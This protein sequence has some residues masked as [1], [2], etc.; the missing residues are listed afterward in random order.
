[1]VEDKMTGSKDPKS[2]KLPLLKPIKRDIANGSS[3][4]TNIFLTIC[5]LAMYIL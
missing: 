2:D 5:L 1:M 4:V 3:E